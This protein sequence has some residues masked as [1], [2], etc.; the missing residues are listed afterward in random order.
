MYGYIYVADKYEGLILV[1]AATL[2]DGNPLNNFLKRDLTF[3]PDGILR[4]ARAI[5]IAGVYAYVCCDAGLVVISL[6]DP[7]NP[8]IKAVLRDPVLKRPHAVQVQ[9]RYAYVCDEEGIKV[10]DVTDL[11]S[12]QAVTALSLPGANNIYLAR[13]YAYVAAG[14]RGL[15]ILD[16]EKPESPASHICPPY[17]E[18]KRDG[19]QDGS[20]SQFQ[21]IVPRRAIDPS[22]A[23]S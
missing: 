15:V 11:A 6:D 22:P 23:S 4:G 20:P 18:I 16:I 8:E 19:P 14:S 5:T 10:L 9:F 1:G 3:N 17:V 12:P 2:L 21:P 7:K 13:T